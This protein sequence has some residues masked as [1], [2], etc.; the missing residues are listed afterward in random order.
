MTRIRRSAGRALC[1]LAGLLLTIGCNDSPTSVRTSGNLAVR[2]TDAPV[3]GLSKVNVFITG[4]TVKPAG[5]P[6][7]R[8]AGE[9][10]LVDLLELRGTTRLLA[11]AGA[12]PGEYEFIQVELDSSRSNVVVEATNETLPLQIASQE[13]KV[14][15]GFTVAP[16]AETVVTLDFDAAASLR[17]PRD[18][19]Y[20]LV[21][22][23][24]MV[25]STMN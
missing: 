6:V 16:A 20:L 24:A 11:T 14:L 19:E 3:D 4:L 10:G 21:P 2:L 17:E 22:V 1:A 5:G 9:V 18:G 7:E 13:V 23:I 25:G 8:I 12:E 15:G